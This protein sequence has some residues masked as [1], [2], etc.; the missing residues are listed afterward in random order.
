MTVQF[1]GLYDLL[2]SVSEC[3]QY[4][5]YFL[6]L[7]NY[8]FALRLQSV[9]YPLRFAAHYLEL[10]FYHVDEDFAKGDLLLL[11]QAW[12]HHGQVGLRLQF[13]ALAAYICKTE[14]GP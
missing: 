11:L 10:T 8:S 1:Q 4:V 7:E 9:T 6:K 3:F 13:G 2:N 12:S 5:L 14:N